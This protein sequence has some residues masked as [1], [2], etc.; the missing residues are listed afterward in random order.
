ME[1]YK[2]LDRFELLYDSDQRLSDL[3][4]AYI[5][6]DLTSI[7]KLVDVDDDLRKAILEQNL[8]SL[9]RLVNGRVLGEVEDLRKALLENNLHSLFRLLSPQ[10]D[11]LRKAV[12]NQ[13]MFSIFELLKDEDLQKFILH[14][15]YHGMYALLQRYTKSE[16]VTA[17][18][19]FWM[20]EISIDEDCFSRGQLQ[21]KKWLITELK[22]CDVDLG[23][24]FLCAGWYGTLAT[25]IFENDIKVDKIRSFDLDPSCASIAEDF[26]RK[27]V[28]DSW[29]FKA[30]TKDINDIDFNEYE[31]YT[32]KDDG[33]LEKQWDVVDTVI[34]TSCEHIP[35][36]EHW[37]AKI[38]RGK[39]VI[40]Q[41]NDYFEIEEHVNCSKDLESFAKQTPI[42]LE[43]FSGELDLGKYKRFMRIGLK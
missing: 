17:F 19:H 8:Y 30:T 15:N 35:N 28:I 11:D 43:M 32:L 29:K 22:R 4:R 24:V 5:D 9:F 12:L 10:Y 26:N 21:S 42:S 33:T 39:L 40:L 41:S 38:P 31:Y 36:F 27:W 23:T 13:N 34:N 16:L 3:R 25:L 6:R 1:A 2:L 20:K 14:D 18:K 37:Y 7:F